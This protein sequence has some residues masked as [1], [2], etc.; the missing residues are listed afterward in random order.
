MSVRKIQV[1]TRSC[2]HFALWLVLKVVEALPSSL[3]EYHPPDLWIFGP[4]EF[5]PCIIDPTPTLVAGC[6]GEPSV[7]SR[8]KI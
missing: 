2:D 4:V 8:F 7:L 1:R 5:T 3:V 6:D